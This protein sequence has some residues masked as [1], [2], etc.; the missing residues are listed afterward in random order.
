[1][2]A[3]RKGHARA[4]QGVAA[5][6]FRSPRRNLPEVQMRR[7]RLRSLHEQPLAQRCRSP[8]WTSN[9]RFGSRLLAHWLSRRC[10]LPDTPTGGSNQLLQAEPRPYVSGRLEQT[11][12]TVTQNTAVIE[13]RATGKAQ[14]PAVDG[15]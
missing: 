4:D 12:P 3:L 5:S 7:A 10:S 2:R 1:M 14:E 6:A 9:K 8:K 13:A 11:K 15:G